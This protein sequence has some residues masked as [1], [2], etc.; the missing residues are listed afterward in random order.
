MADSNSNQILKLRRSL[1][2]VQD[3]LDNPAEVADF[4]NLDRW[5]QW[6]RR[7]AGLPQQQQLMNEQLHAG[8]LT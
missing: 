1:L 6:T 2:T 3:L 4:L 5:R 8:V 7:A